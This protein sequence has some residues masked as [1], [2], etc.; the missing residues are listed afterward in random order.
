M[1]WIRRL[2]ARRRLD[3]DLAEEIQ[4]HLDES[5]EELVADGMSR[6]DATRAARRA[7]GNL[8]RTKDRSRDV[9]RWRVAPHEPWLLVLACS[10]V[11]LTALVAAYFPAR[12]PATIDP[13]RALRSD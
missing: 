11:T 6:D 9:W 7:F 2:V 1:N 4:E 5:A 8:T 10:I 3:R 12:R 13:S